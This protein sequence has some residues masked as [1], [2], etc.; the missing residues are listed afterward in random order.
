MDL[1]KICTVR[2]D[3]KRG[4][5]RTGDFVW[6]AVNNMFRPLLGMYFTNGCGCLAQD[7]T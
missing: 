3:Q 4:V 1:P 7:L 2:G 5:V 6:I